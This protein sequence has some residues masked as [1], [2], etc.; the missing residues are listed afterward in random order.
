MDTTARY[1]VM[2]LNSNRATFS[3]VLPSSTMHPDP[4]ELR[5]QK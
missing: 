3:I 2:T 4:V 5:M 1:T